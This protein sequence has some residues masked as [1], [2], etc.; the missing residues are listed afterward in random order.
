VRSAVKLGLLLASAASAQMVAPPE[1]LAAAAHA[2][3]RQPDEGRAAF[4]EVEP[5]SPVLNFGLRLE[6]GYKIDVPLVAYS[7]GP[8]AWDLTLRITPENGGSPTYLIDRLDVK[9]NMHPEMTLQIP[10][11]F[12]VGEGRYRAE[13]AFFDEFGRVCRR[14]WNINASLDSR[15]RSITPGIPPNT[16]ADLTYSG[17]PPPQGPPRPARI[18]VLLNR[19]E[20][21]KLPGMFIGRLSELAA[22]G[23]AVAEYADYRFQLVSMLSSLLERLPGTEVRLVI[24]DLDRQ[25]ESLR[26]DGFKLADMQ[27]AVHA[28]DDLE[29]AVVSVSELQNQPGRWDMVRHFIE[30]EAGAQNPADVVV[31]LGARIAAT[32]RVP[33]EFP[34]FDTRGKTRFVYL[35][36]VIGTVGLRRPSPLEAGSNRTPGKSSDGSPMKGIAAPEP[37]DPIDVAVGRAK[38]KTIPIHEPTEF[39]K[40]IESLRGR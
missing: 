20:P 40:A 33:R 35:Q 39:G 28:V 26:Q 23:R 8:H 16:V 18:T 17:T 12:L 19:S 7:M 32:E 24:F 9:A 14:E 3:D 13:L 38:G 4:C 10:G 22:R 1:R 34:R 2:L 11:A 5:S 6:A 37:S 21:Y 36:Y 27:K 30:S 31:F 25:S 15:E 29:H